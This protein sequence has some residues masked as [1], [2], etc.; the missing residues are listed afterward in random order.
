MFKATWKLRGSPDP[1]ENSRAHSL[2]YV[3]DDARVAGASCH[4]KIFRKSKSKFAC[5]VIS[6]MAA[7]RSLD[8][9]EALV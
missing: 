3:E 1:H 8:A 7:R 5:A 6:D 9:D 2:C 4:L